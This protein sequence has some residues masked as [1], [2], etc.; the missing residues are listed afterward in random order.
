MTTLY[1]ASQSPRR[2]QLLDQIGVAYETLDVE[3]DES[4]DGTEDPAR[5][6]Q[7]LALEKAR[8]G[9]RLTGDAAPVLAADTGV[10]LDGRLLGKAGDREEA[11]HMLRCLSGRSHDVY[12]AVA[13]LRVDEQF[14]LSRSR[15]C[16]RP[17]GQE[18]CEA[19][20]DSGEPYG[21]AGGYAIQGRGAIFVSR[22]EGS[23]SGV[24]GLPLYETAVLLKA[25][26][27]M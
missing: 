6:V 25:A 19:Y 4:W 18:D 16:F 14:R 2:R 21:K 10:V 26:G 13:L 1:L 24:M 8:A 9:R 11:M 17:L 3:V 27:I 12:S 20:C 15:V 7:R 22:L 5:H 23:Y